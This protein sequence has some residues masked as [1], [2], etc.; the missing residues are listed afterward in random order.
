M[1]SDSKLEVWDVVVRIFH[2]SLASAFLITYITEDDF[3]TLHT[4]T[5]YLIGVLILFRIVWGFIGSRYSRF[6]DF[7][8]PPSSIVAYTKQIIAFSADRYIGHNPAGG[9]MVIALLCTLALTVISGVVAYGG[10]QASG[11][12]SG[13]MATLPHWS[14]ELAEETHEWLANFT[15]ILIFVHVAG[16]LVAS[17]QHGENLIKSMFTG[18]KQSTRTLNQ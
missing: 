3:I 1:I 13:V 2:W 8:Y 9:A 16:V 4:I 7:V 11:P 14:A 12:L 6:S 17:L 10:E 15:L 5:G 18:R